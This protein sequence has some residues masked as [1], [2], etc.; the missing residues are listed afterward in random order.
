[1]EIVINRLQLEQI[2]YVSCKPATLARN[3]EVLVRWQRYVLAAAGLIDMFPRTV[4]I[5][6]LVL[7][8]R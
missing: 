1:M 7:I 2:V 4:H 6:A 5:E 3:S 8:V